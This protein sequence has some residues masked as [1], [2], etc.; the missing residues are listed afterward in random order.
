M[1]R[2]ATRRFCWR[3]V[4]VLLAQRTGSAGATH[5]SC[6]RNASVLPVQ[7]TG[8]AGTTHRLY[9]GSISK[10]QYPWAHI[11]HIWCFS[12]VLAWFCCDTTGVAL[13]LHPLEALFFCALIIHLPHDMIA[14]MAL[15]G[16]WRDTSVP[17]V[18]RTVMSGSSSMVP[19]HGAGQWLLKPI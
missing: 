3:S 8:F 10:T 14:G 12:V 16:R 2:D 6:W 9:A 7:R 19:N 15:H 17:D 1:S 18:A 11:R 13:K 5:R 4:P